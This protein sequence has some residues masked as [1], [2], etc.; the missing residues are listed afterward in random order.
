MNNAWVIPSH[1]PVSKPEP[2]K[3]MRTFLRPVAVLCIAALLGACASPYQAQMAALHNA[4]LAGDVSD[5]EYR[6]EMARLRYY[7]AGWQQ[8]QANDLATAAVITGVAAVALGSH[9][10]HHHHRGHWHRG[11]WHR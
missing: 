3:S 2:L 1:L 10:H 9:G 5:Y 7:D 6:Q 4:R 8:Q 11:H